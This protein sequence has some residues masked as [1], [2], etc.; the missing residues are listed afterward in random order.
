MTKFEFLFRLRNLG[1][2]FF[3]I[4]LACVL[5]LAPLLFMKPGQ[6]DAQQAPAETKTVQ[7]PPGQKLVN[8]SWA[9]SAS[10]CVASWTTRPMRSDELPEPHTLRND[11][12]FP[13]VTFTER[14]YGF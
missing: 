9:C 12:G 14:R 6:A 3:A 1:F 4:G 5:F 10:G 2:F 8:A 7:I 11:S 13:T